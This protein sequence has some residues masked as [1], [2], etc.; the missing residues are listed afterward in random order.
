M[1]SPVTECFGKFNCYSG[2]KFNV[3]TTARQK[4]CIPGYMTLCKAAQNVRLTFNYIFF[5]KGPQLPPFL[6]F[7]FSLPV[8][9][10]SAAYRNS[11]C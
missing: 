6:Y 4:S 10:P 3:L 8:I 2:I 7:L 5:L 1:A 9:F 11:S